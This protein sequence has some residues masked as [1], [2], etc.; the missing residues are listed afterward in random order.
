MTGV[1]DFWRM[2][3]KRGAGRAWRHF[4]DVTLYDLRHG[5]DTDTWLPLDRYEHQPENIV[6][7]VQYQP[8]WTSEVRRA[9][10]ALRCEIGDLSGHDFVDLGSGKGKVCFIAAGY[11][12]RS[13]HGVEFYRPLHDIAE[14]NRR[15]LGLPVHFHHADAA[16]W[17]YPA[18]PLVIYGYNPFS[19]HLWRRVLDRLGGREYVVVYNNPVHASLFDGRR[20]LF[21]NRLSKWENLRTVIFSS[22]AS[23]PASEPSSM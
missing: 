2:A 15:R 9:L 8:S 10:D 5:T 4:H 6:H 19:E 22:A 16:E 11:G 13:V 12:F 14:A 23:G 18:G 3:R 20:I 21:D 17:D 7:A 1:R